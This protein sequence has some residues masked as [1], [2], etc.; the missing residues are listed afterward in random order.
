[1][2]V[3]PVELRGHYSNSWRNS[4]ALFSDLITDMGLET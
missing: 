1:V 2:L 4:V 3:R